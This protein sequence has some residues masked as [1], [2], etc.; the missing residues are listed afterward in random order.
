MIYLIIFVG[1][2]IDI[3]IQWATMNSTHVMAASKNN[4]VVWQYKTPKYS[5]IIG[6]NR[7][8]IRMYH[9][10]DTPSG[11]VEVIQDLDQNIE[12]PTNI[13]AST[14]PICCLTSSNKVLIIGRESGLIQ[15][16]ALPHTAL[17]NRYKM[18]SRPHKMA[19]NCNS[20]YVKS[21]LP[22]M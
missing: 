5:S 19:I 1:I 11:A 14:D 15:Y 7:N 13:F 4:F 20:T 6:G 3:E 18:I 21:T 16:Y 10:D 17:Y 2:Y 8:R 12:T 22:H 9:I